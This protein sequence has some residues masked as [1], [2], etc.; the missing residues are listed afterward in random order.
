[1]LAMNLMKMG[2][3]KLGRWRLYWTRQVDEEKDKD[4]KTE[5]EQKQDDQEIN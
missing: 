1:M 3:Y 2:K 4:T 5:E